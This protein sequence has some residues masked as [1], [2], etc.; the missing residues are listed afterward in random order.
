M[1]RDYSKQTLVELKFA[2]NW[3]RMGPDSQDGGRWSF[4]RTSLGCGGIQGSGQIYE[5]GV[6]QIL[7]GHFVWI[8]VSGLR[9][10]CLIVLED[11]ENKL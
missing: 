2:P 9:S 7:G 10:V 4:A 3:R 8:L 6:P 11:L 1:Q 5:A